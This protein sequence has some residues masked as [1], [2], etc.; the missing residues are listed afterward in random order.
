MNL[1]NVQVEVP[2]LDLMRARKFYEKY[3][4]FVVKAD[5]WDYVEFENNIILRKINSTAKRSDLPCEQKTRI[6]FWVD[7]IS[8][9]YKELVDAG[10]HIEA[11]P[12]ESEEE[13]YF[14]FLDSEDNCCKI[15]QKK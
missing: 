9:A 15:I 12:Y 10:I 6:I 4:G 8:L 5:S 2:I 13:H 11:P 7:K 3:F 1:K 14:Y